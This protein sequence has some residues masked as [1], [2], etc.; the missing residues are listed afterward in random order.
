[1]ANPTLPVPADRMRTDWFG[2]MAEWLDRPEHFRSLG[3]RRAAAYLVD[4]V[5]LVPV[6]FAVSVAF[7][8]LGI[9]SFGLLS[10]LLVLAMGAVPLAYHTLTIG[11]PRSSTWGMRLFDVEMRSWTGGR[12]DY[13]Q[14]LI[15]TALFYGSMTLS[16]G[17][18]VLFGLIN[19]RR[20]LVHDI[21]TGMVAVRSSA[22]GRAE[23][24]PPGDG[25]GMR[26]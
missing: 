20:R 6:C 21:L 19:R 16:G 26:R 25:R 8:I 11:G 7:S 22:L 23:I 4:L 1:M 15:A 5:I 9:L 18:I 10:P 17:L 24:I 14:A 3:R 13:L 12:P 2:A